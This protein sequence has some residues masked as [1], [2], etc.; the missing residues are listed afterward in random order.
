METLNYEPGSSGA[1]LVV[2]ENGRVRVLALDQKQQW[3]LGRAARSGTPDIPFQ[4][5]IVSRRHGWLMGMDEEWYYVD[6][7]RNL[8]GIFLNGRRI[9]RPLS[10]TR[11]PVTLKDGDVL[12]IDSGE[13][14]LEGEIVVML[15]TTRTVKGNWAVYPLEEVG[16]L[17]MDADERSVMVGDEEIALTTREFDILYKLLSY[18]KRTFTRAQ[19]MDEFWDAD[20]QSGTRTVDVYM[21][22]LRAKLSGCHSFEIQTVHG[23]GYKAVIK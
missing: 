22:K 2:L 20:S 19:L 3:L 7:P 10:G 23:L 12:R 4:S 17:V 9:E 11:K 14:G 15:Y 16:E 8:N 13:A 5:K 6:N 1:K 21:T 18:P